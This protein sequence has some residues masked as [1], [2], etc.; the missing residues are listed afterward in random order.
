[1]I[2]V[3]IIWQQGINHVC[4]SP[5]GQWVASASFD[6]SVKLWNGTTGKFVATFRHVLDVYQIRYAK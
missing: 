2:L 3:E 1:M 5:D 4:F 6:N